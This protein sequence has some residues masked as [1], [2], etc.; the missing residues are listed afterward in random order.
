MFGSQLRTL[1]LTVSHSLTRERKEAKLEIVILFL[2]LVSIFLICCRSLL[3]DDF[4]N[5]CR[6][7]LRGGVRERDRTP[8]EG[9]QI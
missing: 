7:V 2:C 9:Q 3:S 5:A 8:P 4:T 1:D 6:G